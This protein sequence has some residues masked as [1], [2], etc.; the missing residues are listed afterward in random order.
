MSTSSKTMLGLLP[1]NSITTGRPFLAAAV[2]TARPAAVE[3]VKVIFATA[4][5]SASE[6]PVS[7]PPATTLSTPA[8][9][10]SSSARRASRMVV[11]GVSGAGL[12]TTVHP[13]Q[14]AA[15]TFPAAITSA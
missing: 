13:T 9:N 4:G 10:P 8:G 12:T 1:P 11:S 2:A 6:A 5:C 15:A 7:L 14:S 3:P